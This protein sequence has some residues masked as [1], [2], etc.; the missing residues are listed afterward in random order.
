MVI[1][2]DTSIIID[3]LRRRSVGGFTLLEQLIE[4]FSSEDSITV[5]L[6]TI[7]ELYRGL[8]TRNISEEQRLLQVISPYATLPYTYEVAEL[9]GKITRDSKVPV[10]FADAAIAATAI[11][12]D[13]SLATLNK[14]HF[15][16]ISGLELFELDTGT[17]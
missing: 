16:D 5:S 9:A 14:R 13:A 10:E 17:S 11:L 4:K 2:I 6:I 7:Q 1:V 8:S 12:N 3:H 15:K